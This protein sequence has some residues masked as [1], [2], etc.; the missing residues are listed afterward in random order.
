MPRRSTPSQPDL[1]GGPLAADPA[2]LVRPAP[3]AAEAEQLARRLPPDVHF[4][5]SSWSFPGWAGL[6]YAEA[7]EPAT[8]ARFGLAAY[9]RHPLLNAV[10]LD[11]TFYAPLSAHELGQYARS[12]PRT[13]RFVVKAWSGLTTAPESARGGRLG[14]DA[15]RFLDAGCARAQVIEPTVEG[16]GE[17]LGVLLFQFSPLGAAHTRD[18]ERFLARLAAFLDALPRGPP[19]AVELRD[20]QLLG[21]AYEAALAAA[22]VAH[23]ASVHPRM[24]PVHEQA[25]PPAAGPLVVR[26]VLHPAQEYE[27]ARARYAP[28][29]RLVDPDPAN[30]D[31][32]VNWI[33]PALGAGRK[34]YLIANN[35]AEG[36]APCT[37]VELARRILDRRAAQP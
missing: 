23:C 22:G 16:L 5:T 20:A 18:P 36:C 9:A 35:K 37:L 14:R 8:L 27:A 7:Y 25:P 33:A 21:P 4:G 15:E 10:G 30:R 24:P 6:V 17:T 29:N 34:V 12:V 3:A 31:N 13:F 11:R 19:Y 32:I 2:R 28:F 26:W 1:F